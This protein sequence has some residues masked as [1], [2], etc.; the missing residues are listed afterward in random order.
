[1]E[2]VLGDRFRPQ[3]TLLYSEIVETQ[4]NWENLKNPSLKTSFWREEI[5]QS[6]S[7]DD[8][9]AYG[10]RDQNA[11]TSY[12]PLFT[13]TY[14]WVQYLPELVPYHTSCV[15]SPI[16]RVRN[17]IP[18]TRGFVKQIGYGT[19][20]T[21]RKA[22]HPIKGLLLLKSSLFLERFIAV[23]SL[24]TAHTQLTV[25]NEHFPLVCKFMR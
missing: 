12:N 8:A 13:V 17:R 16:K 15:Y 9:Q 18:A 14:S 23:G 25:K 10:S 20:F 19:L 7:S 24:V 2:H 1:M 4:S 3:H 5:S 11:N 21:K 22:A 6:L